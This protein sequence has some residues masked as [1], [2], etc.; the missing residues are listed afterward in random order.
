MTQGISQLYC[1]NR[2]IEIFS[3]NKG[4]R[5]VVTTSNSMSERLK[6]LWD[7]ISL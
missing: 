5:E 1:S 6:A 7:V 3:F 4:I 2:S